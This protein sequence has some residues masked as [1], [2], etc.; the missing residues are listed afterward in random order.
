MGD[1][2]LNVFSIILLI[3]AGFNTRTTFGIEIC[4]ETIRTVCDCLFYPVFSV[5]CSHKSLY[6]YPDLKTI[7]VSDF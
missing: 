2:N 7:Q 1:H 4:S 3:V 6:D 5:R